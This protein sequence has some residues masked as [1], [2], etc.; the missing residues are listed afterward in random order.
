[1]GGL[2][3][4]VALGADRR[5]LGLALGPPRV[6]LGLPLEPDRLGI[7]R[8]APPRRLGLGPTSA[9]DRRR[10]RV[11]GDTPGPR[12]VALVGRLRLAVRDA[13]VLLGVRVLLLG[14]ALCLGRLV[15]LG[16]ELLLAQVVVADR[17]ELFLLDDLLLLRGAGEGTGG[18]GDGLTRIGLLL[19]LRVADV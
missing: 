3:L 14:V 2:R 19:D 10:R 1:T 6:G 13:C 18:V 7:L 11:R 15:D 12:A 16:D 8:A 17:D 4:G 5:G 9:L